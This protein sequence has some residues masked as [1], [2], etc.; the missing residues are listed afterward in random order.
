MPTPH[1]LFAK[2]LGR[3]VLQKLNAFDISQVQV[4]ERVK[5]IET[6]D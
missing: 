3:G 1:A 6:L 5:G 2:L 4:P